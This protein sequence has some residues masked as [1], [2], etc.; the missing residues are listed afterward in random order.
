MIALKMC[1]RTIVLLLLVSSA[2][3]HI[4]DINKIKSFVKIFNVGEL[5]SN[6]TSNV[7]WR[8]ILKDCAKK[9]T[10]SC[11]QKNVYTYLDNTFTD[12]DNITVFDGFVMTRNN[13]DY[14]KYSEE[15]N[16]QNSAKD[17]NDIDDVHVDDED[18]YTSSDEGR[19]I[20]DNNV[21][22]LS[23]LEEV[24]TA[25][26]DKAIK[27]LATRDYEVQLPNFFFEGTSI[28][29]SPKEIDEDGALIRVDF[30][31]RAV[32]TEGRFFKK[33]SEP[34]LFLS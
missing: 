19:N 30:K 28:K 23:P 16:E 33:I 8:G 5:R 22:P 25:V 31:N 20:D 15:Y 29:L 14:H 7:L 24:T 9:A 1:C 17:K 6:D 2:Y 4:F 18:S 10:F 27:F 21:E 3:S 13:L 32:S 12:R 26:H 34:L 11:I